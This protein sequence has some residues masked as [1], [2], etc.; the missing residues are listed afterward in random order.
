MHIRWTSTYNFL[1]INSLQRLTTSNP[2]RNVVAKMKV[3]SRRLKSM[4]N[5]PNSV[6][7]GNAL[8]DLPV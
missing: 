1:R 8:A 5:F 6:H 3:Q 7:P 2:P 4:S